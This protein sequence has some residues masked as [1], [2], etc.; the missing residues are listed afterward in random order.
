[1]LL[2]AVRYWV[3]DLEVGPTQSKVLQTH[4]VGVM[5][6][7]LSLSVIYCPIQLKCVPRTACL[8]INWIQ[9][10]TYLTRNYVC[11]TIPVKNLTNYHILSYILYTCM[12]VCIYMYV[13]IYTHTHTY[14]HTHIYKYIHTHT[15]KYTHAYIHIYTYMQT[16]IH[17]MYI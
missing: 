2:E 17:T 16:H 6:L 7:H 9:I 10:I 8:Y 14:T 3:P 11:L 1:M 12:Y 13:Y 4:W 5:Q 15:H